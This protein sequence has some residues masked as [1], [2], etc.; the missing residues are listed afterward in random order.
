MKII[1]DNNINS[2]C[3]KIA[4]ASIE[5]YVNVV[6]SNDKLWSIIEQKSKEIEGNVP[7]KLIGEIKNI[8][9]S[10]MAYKAFGKDPSRYR[11]S[12]EALYRRI[13]RGLGLY[14]VNSVV[15]IN[16]LV[17]LNSAY[18]VGT[19]DLDKISGDI[20]FTIADEGE[21]YLGI[22]RGELNISNLPVFYDDKGK[23]GST[24]SDSV[25][26]M[27]TPDTNHIL[28]NIIS[29]NG[30]EELG[31]YMNEACDYL[32]KYANGKILCKEISKG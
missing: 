5:A 29:F 17:S 9:D 27:I 13:A 32:E 1:I 25:R 20:H 30:D 11:L 21:T 10:R 23:F 14:K 19:Y 8:A 18:S 22:G 15:D 3:N 4:I 6:E 26:A 16:N 31:K 7:V 2:K 24:T 28:M 12:S